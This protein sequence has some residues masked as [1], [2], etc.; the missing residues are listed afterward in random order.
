MRFIDLVGCPQHVGVRHGFRALLALAS[1]AFTA[2]A[3]A[4]AWPTSRSS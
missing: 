3:A 2:A 4:Q 1:I